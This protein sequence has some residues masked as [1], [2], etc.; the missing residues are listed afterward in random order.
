M[1]DCYENLSQT[2]DIIGKIYRVLYIETLVQ[3]T[4]AGY[5]KTPLKPSLRVIWYEAVGRAE[6]V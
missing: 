6:G 1:R 3:V 5:I 2:F 4:V